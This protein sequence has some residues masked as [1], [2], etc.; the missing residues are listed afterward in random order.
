VKVA[1][2]DVGRTGNPVK[3]CPGHFRDYLGHLGGQADPGQVMFGEGECRGCKANG[4]HPQRDLGFPQ[5][6]YL[7]ESGKKKTAVRKQAHDSGD[8]ATIF[9][10]LAGETRFLTPDGPR[11]LE[12]CAGQEVLVLTGALGSDRGGWAPAHIHSFGQQRLWAVTLKRNKQTKVLHATDGHRWLVRRPD[13][14]V[15]TQDLIPGHRLAHIRMERYSGSLDHEGI[16]HGFHFGDGSVQVRGERTYGIVTLWGPK[17]DLADYFREVARAEYEAVTEGGVEGLRFTSGMKDYRKELPSLHA[18]AE[19]LY[20]WLAGYVAADG[21]VG[22][23]GQVSLSSAVRENLE[24]VRDIATLLGIGTY[25]ITGKM[26][27]GFGGERSMLF[28]MGLSAADLPEEFFLR[29]DHRA[30]CNPAAQERFGW[31]VVS[32]EPTG[33]VEEVYCA[34]VPGTESFA[35][36]DNIHSGNCPFCGSGQVI[37]RSDRTVECEYCHTCFTVQ[38]QPQ[39]PAFPQT[40]NGMPMQVPGMPGQIGGPPAAPDPAAGGMPGQDPMGAAPGGDEDGGFPPGEDDSGADG[41]EDEGGDDAPPWAKKSMLRT[42]SGA[43]LAW[44]NYLKHLAIKFA[45][46]KDAVIERVRKGR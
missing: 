21:S 23:T 6:Q 15:T 25:G 46:D 40:I 8:G 34:V 4:P 32:V 30:R 17:R 29:S 41:S 5:D 7:S 22:P 24:R 38:V 19:Y 3:M 31:T 16:R 33:R 36:E 11:T 42:A 2:V 1:L 13:R 39:F 14:V 10:C 35:L 28:Q 43:S 20:G 37:A 45:D 27:E 44:D 9:H 18:P 26:R 12:E